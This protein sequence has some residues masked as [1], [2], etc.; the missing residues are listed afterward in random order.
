MQRKTRKTR[1]KTRIAVAGAGQVG[2][3]HI[4]ILSN[5]NQVQLAGIVD[6]AV[7]YERG[8][9]CGVPVYE[10]LAELFAKDRPDGVVIA[11]PNRLHVEQ[12]LEC[13][14]AGIPALIEK[15]VAHTL[16]AGLRLCEAAE[17]AQ[18]PI[19]VGHHRRHSAI[20]AKAVEIID[21]GVL[22]PIVA[23]MGSFLLYKAESEH[24]YDGPHA[25]RREIGGGPL[26]INM[27]H[28][29]SNLRTLCGEIEAVQAFSSNATR[30][31]AV[32]DSAAI[33]FRFVNGA[34]GTFLLS[35]TAAS[36]HSWEHTVGED[37][38]F[39]PA[40]AADVDCYHLTGASGSLSIPTMRLR[41]FHTVAERSWHKPLERSIAE[42][43]L[44]DPLER[45]MEHFGEVVRGTAKPLVSARD[46]LQN[47]R[48][49]EAIIEAAQTG[50]TVSVLSAR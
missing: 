5:S 27:I 37:P 32:E 46:G 15:P 40:H 8:E 39:D 31:F 1:S 42:V 35:D 7:A 47:L 9:A 6:P 24:Y 38:S 48:V 25:W 36:D 17:A 19:L 26:L 45:Q 21:S 28:E 29:I 20:M 34:L 18:V 22:G 13:I 50:G 12:G 10:S 11:T 43:E 3:R 44:V 49:V 2:S 16:E 41:C 30:H 14:A 23:V 4:E 33:T